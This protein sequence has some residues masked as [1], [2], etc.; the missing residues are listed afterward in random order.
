MRKNKMSKPRTLNISQTELKNDQISK[1]SKQDS[2]FA[3]YE[4]SESGNSNI[5]NPN[6]L[7]NYGLSR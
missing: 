5:Y 7:N 6:F 2:E 4:I 1:D 3:F